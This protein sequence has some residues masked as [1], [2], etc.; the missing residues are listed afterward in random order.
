M[1]NDKA[2]VVTGLTLT[3]GWNNVVRLSLPDEA[4]PRHIDAGRA[5]RRYC[6]ELRRCTLAIAMSSLL[7]LQA[8][9]A[10]SAPSADGA[11]NAAQAE[12]TREAGAIELDRIE[13]TGTRIRGGATPSP[14]VTLGS[15]RIREEGFADLGEVVRSLPQNFSGGQNPG[16]IPFTVSGAGAQNTNL[17]GGSALNLRGLGADA[18][19]TL[20][21]GRRMAYDGISQAVDISAIPVEAVDRIE[22]VADGASAIYGS[23]AVGGVGN[24]IL[25]RDFEGVAVGVGYGTA[26]GGGLT[27]REYTATAGHVWTSGG[28]IVTYKDATTDPIYARQRAYTRFLRDPY[29][30]YPGSDRR[31]GLVSLSQM[32]GTQAEL[33]VDAFRTERS[34]RYGA[35]D[36]RS[37]VYIE[38]T[39]DATTTLLSPRVDVFLPNDWTLSVGAT[40]SRSRLDHDQAITLAASG[41]LLQRT[42]LCYCNEGRSYEVGF[43]GPLLAWSAGDVRLAVGAGQRENSFLEYNQITRV[44]AIEGDEAARFAYA[45]LHVPVL[46]DAG[47]GSQRLTLTGAARYEDYDSFG[48]V[49]TPKLGV[50]YGPGADVTLKASWG[51]SF[52]APT[53][54]QLNRQR[55][56]GFNYATAYGGVG[57]P[58]G[59]TVLL[60]DGGNPNL[61]PERARTW[62]ASVAFHPAAVPGLEAE[63]SWFDIDYTD[64]VVA[65]ITPTSQA[66]RNPAF[67]EFVTYAPTPEQQAAAIAGSTFLNYIRVPYDPDTVVAL[68]HAYYTNVA[69]QRIRGL[70]LSGAYGFDLGTGRLTLRGASSWIQSTQQATAAEFDLAGT[71]HNPPKLSG[72]AGGVW[73]RD[74][75]SAAV[76]AN[77]RHGLENVA[78]GETTASFTTVDTTL[79]YAPVG[80]GRALRDWALALSVQNVFDRPP[81][82]HDTTVLTPYLVPPYD[83]TNFSAIGRYYHVTVSRHW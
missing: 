11:R 5:G 14:V 73:A 81:P 27:T 56:T 24:V 46:G 74:G 2:V 18:T 48:S 82:L 16:V 64:R 26:D 25:R 3:R 58:P 39:P 35:Q 60:L 55:L 15:E 10:Q 69:R 50:V 41:A 62:T 40:R 61:E 78:A 13:V 9:W 54:F 63:L 36:N 77:Y 30:L 12:A 17:S 28:L 68:V 29:T 72:R 21:N 7:P 65:P 20:L 59:A 47:A 51:R 66:L 22:V 53:L 6:T 31:S 44:A 71:L 75:F 42:Q 33:R 1:S 4:Y 49:L 67:A 57:T 83:A 79:R 19:L 52:K 34:Q 23:D 76:F 43:E 38:A 70:D 45:E 8:V 32:L 37:N 80:Q